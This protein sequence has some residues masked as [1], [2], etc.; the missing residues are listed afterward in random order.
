MRN[1]CLCAISFTLLFFGLSSCELTKLSDPVVVS[2]V[3]N[4]YNLKPWEKLSVHNRSFQL[5]LSTRKNQVCQNAVIDFEFSKTGNRLAL[6]LLEIQAPKDCTP[7]ND[8]A[9]AVADAGSLPSGF[10]ELSIDLENTVFNK[11]QLTVTA[12][13]YL[14]NMESSDGFT[15]LHEELF[16]VPEES[17]WGYITYEETDAEPVAKAF[18]DDLS[19]LSTGLNFDK[20][21]YGHFQISDN[22]NTVAISGRPPTT[23]IKQFVFQLQ[24]DRLE[25][26]KRLAGQY[27]A[28]HGGTVDFKLLTWQG[29]EI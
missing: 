13:R 23:R 14:V 24:R 12:N 11:G 21:Y 29:E 4:E 18:V 19:Q 3:E 7:G 25:D 26:I 28:E 15:L 9:T 22:K 6:S 5:H 16:R 20:G 27:R 8:P 2:D 1:L 17:I 10:Y